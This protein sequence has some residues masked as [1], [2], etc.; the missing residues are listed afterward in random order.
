MED[1]LKATA[2]CILT[3][4]N[5]AAF[6][7]MGFDKARARRKGR[8]V[9]ERTLFMAAACFGALGG[10]LGMHVFRHKT[11]HWYFRLFFPAM[12]AV[13]AVILTILYLNV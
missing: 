5:A 4:M 8:R 11:K 9:P 2:V 3:A 6:C 13:Q 10:V 12:L 1:V 7:L